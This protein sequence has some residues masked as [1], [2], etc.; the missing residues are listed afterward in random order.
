M[1]N[2]ID[3]MKVQLQLLRHKLN[4]QK[5]V[6]DRLLQQ[7][8]NRNVRR[9]N[10]DTLIMTIVTVVAVPYC[11][12]LFW[13][14]HLSL[15]FTV[16]TVL[17]LVVAIV[18]TFYAHRGIRTSELINS[19]TA[20]VT[21]RIGRMKLLYARWLR[22]SIPFIICWLAWAAYEVMTLAGVSADERKGILVGGAIGGIVGGVLGYFNYRRTQRLASEILEQTENKY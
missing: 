15:A 17:F 5:I 13:W 12:G 1:D 19:S 10:R 4:D 11:A 16:V 14:M 18:Y 21:Q 6:N 8:I 2:T 22:F 20:E 3:E 7:I 9:I